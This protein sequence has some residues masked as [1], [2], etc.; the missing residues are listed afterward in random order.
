MSLSASEVAQIVGGRVVN[1]D[2]LGDALLKIRINRPGELATSKNDEIAFFFSKEYQKELLSTQAGILLTGE[3]FVQPLQASGLPLWKTTAI[4]ACRDPYFGMALLTGRFADELSSVAHERVNRSNYLSEITKFEAEIHP[5]AVLDPTA[6]IGKGV[7]IGPHCTVEANARVG[8]GTILYP[9]CYIGRDVNV[10]KQCVLFPRV[11]LYEHTQLGDRVRLHAGVVIGADGF[12]YAPRFE[13][14]TVAGHQKIYHFGR[15]RIGSDVEV[16]ANSMIDRSTFGETW[17]GDQV[18]IDN[19]VHVG[20]NARID[21][22]AI[23][24]GGVGLAGSASIGK[25]VYVGG[26]AGVSNK[27]HLGDGSK[28]GGMTLVSKDVPAG[29]NAVGNPQREHSDHFK[30]H[31]ILNRMAAERRKKAES[32]KSD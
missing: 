13:N 22:G 10:G 7:K 11:T 29:G 3:P 6:V 30:V 1:S 20:H 12:G 23:I 15:V 16:G 5:L 18:K 25:F 14:G 32:K 24:C 4:I 8:D 2:A 9:G 26:M 19:H 27:V 17:I 21:H 28:V 31:A